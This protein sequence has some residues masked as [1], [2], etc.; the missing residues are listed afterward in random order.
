MIISSGRV[1][2]WRKNCERMI[3]PLGLA[4]FLVAIVASQVPR[5]IVSCNM[6][7]FVQHFTDLGNLNDGPKDGEVR[8]DKPTAAPFESQSRYRGIVRE[9]MM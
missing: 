2:K 6:T 8:A 7:L 4:M 1:A 3:R 9:I 5:K